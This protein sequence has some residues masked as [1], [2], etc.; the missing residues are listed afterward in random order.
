MNWLEKC[1]GLEQNVQIDDT[2][3][4]LIDQNN[5][6]MGNPVKLYV[7]GNDFYYQTEKGAFQLRFLREPKNDLQETKNYTAYACF[8]SP[9]NVHVHIVKFN[10][11]HGVICAPDCLRL[12]DEQIKAGMSATYGGLTVTLTDD[13]HLTFTKGE[14]SVTKEVLHDSRYA[15]KFTK[16]YIS[17]I[18]GARGVFRELENIAEHGTVEKV[19]MFESIYKKIEDKYFGKAEKER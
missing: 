12:E 1:N 14:K 4:L 18:N 5:P 8:Y 3:E 19:P 16:K 2:Y 9:D 10:L 7:K 15:W 11:I 6:V 13:T 17:G